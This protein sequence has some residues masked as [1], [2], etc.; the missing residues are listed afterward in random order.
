MTP[1]GGGM[2]LAPGHYHAQGVLRRSDGATNSVA[3]TFTAPLAGRYRIDTRIDDAGAWSITG[4]LLSVA[5]DPIPFPR[6][7]LW[8]RR[9]IRRATG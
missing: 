8:A 4:D 5:P 1:T 3:S 9:Q 6:F 2:D 7:R